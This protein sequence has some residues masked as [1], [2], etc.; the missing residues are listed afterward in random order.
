[1]TELQIEK[2]CALILLQIGIEVRGAK[3]P[4]GVRKG[5]SFWFKN[6]NRS[7]G[8]IF[9]IRPSGLKRHVISL[10][11]GPYATP[12]LEHINKTATNEAYLVA[13]AF[14]GQLDEKFE[15]KINDF[16]LQSNWII[17][18]GFTIE[19][20]SKNSELSD[21]DHLI[22]SVRYVM[23][24]LIAAIAELIGY[25]EIIEPES[26]PEEEGNLT[27]ALIKKRERSPRNRLLCLLIHGERCGVCGFTHKAAY[28]LEVGSI[29]EVHHIEPLAEIDTPKPYDPRTDL[30]PLCPNCHRAI[31]KKRPAFTPDELKELINL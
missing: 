8:P 20:T 5:L 21:S 9:S 26:L 4:S 3:K 25:E 27:L 1:M 17:A 16:P 2:I 22:D 18:S 19:I 10:S 24:P 13:Y 6:Y 12:C 28:G 14:I 7:N 29:L 31:H 23:L 11:F 15:V 30:I